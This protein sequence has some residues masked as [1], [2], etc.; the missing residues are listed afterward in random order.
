MEYYILD[1]SLAVSK[2]LH[3][4]QHAPNNSV[5]G[6]F[7]EFNEDAHSTNIYFKLSKRLFFQ[8]LHLGLK[9][10]NR[11]TQTDVQTEKVYI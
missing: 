1:K 9:V 8:V 6:P 2:A 11:M 4:V 10:F 3:L 5:V 7:A